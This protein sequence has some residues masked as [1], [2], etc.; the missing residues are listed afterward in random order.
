M[1]DSVQIILSISL[2]IF[3]LS[4]S[5]CLINFG[6]SLRVDYD[7]YREYEKFYNEFHHTKKIK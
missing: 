6:L 7:K 3:V 5:V 4:V 2:V 1:I